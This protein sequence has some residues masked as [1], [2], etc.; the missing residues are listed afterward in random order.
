[1]AVLSKIRERSIL[2]IG[3]IGFCLLAFIIGDIINSGGF[4]VTRNIGSVN[5]TDIPASDFK[6]ELEGMQGGSSTQATNSIFNREVETIL[7][8]ER[9]EKAGIL[10]GKDHIFD[11]YGQSYGQQPQFMNALGQFD[12]AKFNE[13]LV[14]LKKDNPALY[15]NFEAS[16][17]KVEAFAKRQVYV[18]MVKGGFFTTNIEGKQR[19]AQDNDKVNFDYVYVPYNTVN[20]D[21]VKVTDE[22][23]LAYMK[24]DA[25]KY[26][27]EPT[28]DVEYVLIDNKPSAQDEADAKK[29]IESFLLPKVKYNAETAKNDT[30]AGFASIPASQVAQFVSEA[31]DTPYDTVYVTK[32]QLP[33]EFSEQI[34]NTP[35]GQVFGPYKDNGSY[36][37]T[38]MMSKK[39][40]ATVKAQHILIGYTGGKAPDP[41]ITMTKEEAKAKADQL[42][43]QVNANPSAMGQLV[44]ENSV[45]KGSLA[46]QGIYDNIPKGQMVPTFD[47]F[48]FDNPIGKTG[49]VETDFGFHV[50]R[51][52]DKY[53]GI[54][55]ATIAVKTNPSEKT[56]TENFN[57]ATKLEMDA[58]NGKKFEDLAKA[59]G[60]TPTPANG[61]RSYD[62]A[63]PGVGALRALV[64]WAYDGDTKVGDVKIFDTSNGG[65]VVAR[66]KNINDNGLISLEQAK[67]S[68]L[69][70]VRNEKKA[71]IIRKK[72]AGTTLDAVSKAS[73]SS[74]ANAT[75]I[76]F[77]NPM[78]SGV[79]VEPKVVGK[80]FGL[81][82]GKTSQ[83]IDGVSG[84]YMVT[85]KS[86]EKAAEL[87][88]YTSLIN[89]ANSQAR[90]MAESRLTQ[91][92]KDA[93]DI[94]DNR[95]QFN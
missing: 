4:G 80:A 49:V 48:I 15:Q 89:S 2:L 27:A 36:K 75:G 33:A 82:A 1:M 12:K 32:A 64:R 22:E 29:E 93:A 55:V 24:K 28:R 95:F 56:V 90:N 78:I 84:V 17:P 85:T 74:I 34:Y 5:G 86:V 38:R 18:N 3:I 88:N 50:I 46:N 77:S 54:Q 53:E 37:L 14:N 42:L 43:V 23:L 70:L 83:L 20:D 26:K 65:R 25:K 92:M 10:V 61:L 11:V 19:Y 72:M 30:I 71:E 63:V 73:G 60:F 91:A 51:I 8:N 59:G 69:P 41:S 31:S 6:R 40:G 67:V 94:E 76:A 13:F 21:Q 62:E 44:A 47:A 35:V 52:L 9:I 58:R 81:A 66:L 7:Y 57:K 68:V 39:P 87:P 45:D 16:R 79:G